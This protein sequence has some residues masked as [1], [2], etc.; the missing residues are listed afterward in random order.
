MVRGSK[1]RLKDFWAV[2][3]AVYVLLSQ[4]AGVSP[5]LHHWLHGYGWHLDAGGSGCG[6]G[7]HHGTAEGC[8]VNHDS[9]DGALGESLDCAQSCL[10]ELFAAGVVADWTGRRA[11]VF[12]AF[13]EAVSTVVR[14]PE[15]LG[16]R[17]FP[18]VRGPPVV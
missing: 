18:R 4:W 9:H 5:V 15:T 16:V 3:V 17:L 10:V 2:V 1:D 13:H 6:H 8:S 7:V 11:W 12:A 14:E